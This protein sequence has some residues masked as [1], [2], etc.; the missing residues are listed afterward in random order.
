MCVYIYIYIY[1][2]SEFDKNVNVLQVLIFRCLNKFTI[3]IFVQIFPE[4]Y[5][6]FE[7]TACVNVYIYITRE[8][9]RE[10]IILITCPKLNFI[11]I[12]TYRCIYE[13]VCKCMCVCG[14]IYHF[15]SCL[16]CSNFILS[17]SEN[18]SDAVIAR[19]IILTGSTFEIP[20]ES[21]CICFST[22]SLQASPP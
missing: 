15:L 1:I 6:I 11:F 3:R 12:C 9:E 5:S 18:K 16:K 21:T 14:G 8:R 19:E 10:I 2:C 22:E 7:R 17:G 20:I 13:C 4:V